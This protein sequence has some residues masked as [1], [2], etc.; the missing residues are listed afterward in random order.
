MDYSTSPISASSAGSFI[1]PG[2]ASNIHTSKGT[3]PDL[4]NSPLPIDDTVE[5]QD[6]DANGTADWK[7]PIHEEETRSREP[8]TGDFLDLTG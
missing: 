2:I 7:R 3:V 1:P 6:Q 5:T 4:P 8:S